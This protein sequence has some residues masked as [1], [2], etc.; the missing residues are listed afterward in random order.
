MKKQREK[1]DKKDWIITI[2]L[3]VFF[4]PMGAAALLRKLFYQQ[5]YY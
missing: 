3:L 4:L 5:V 2:C 1:W